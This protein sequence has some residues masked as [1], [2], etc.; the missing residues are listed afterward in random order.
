MLCH[1]RG[2]IEIARTRRAQ[3]DHH[4]IDFFCREIRQCLV[5]GAQIVGAKR[6]DAHVTDVISQHFTV[7]GRRWFGV[8]C[9]AGQQ[10][11]AA[12]QTRQQ[13]FQRRTID[14]LVLER[15]RIDEIRFQGADCFLDFRGSEGID[16]NFWLSRGARSGRWTWRLRRNP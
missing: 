12:V 4:G 11:R 13:T 1:F 2:N 14:F 5:Q 7:K 6:S 10:E 9:F 15:V 8:G 3:I 16:R